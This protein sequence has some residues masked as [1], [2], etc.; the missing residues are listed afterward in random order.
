MHAEMVLIL[1]TVTIFAQ[2]GLIAWKKYQFK[3]Y[4]VNKIIIII[5]IIILLLLLLIHIL[6]V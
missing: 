6:Y 2:I 3:S 1:F 5:N 4:Q